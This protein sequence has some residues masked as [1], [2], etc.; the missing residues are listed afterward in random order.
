MKIAAIRT[1]AL[2]APVDPP[3]ASASGVQSRRGGLLVEVETDSG[4]VGI[5]EAGLGGGA[6]ATVI[7]KDLAPMLVG[8][9]PLM[10]EG[11]WQKMF[12]RT[13]QYGRRGVVMQGISGID[14]A[15]WDIAGKVAKLPVYKLLGACRDR[16]EAYASGGFYQEGKTAA[17][18]AGEAEGY[19][20]RGFKGM[21][22]K[23]GRN[24]STQTHLRELI[25][26]KGFCE[27]DPSEDLARVAAVRQALGPHAKLMVDVNCAWSPAFA[28]E[29]GR[30]M[31]RYNLYW[32]EEPVATDD[33]EGSARVADALATPIAG[34]E[35]EM[36]LYA[37]RE[38]I[39]RGAVDIVQLDI[40]WS[41][42]FSEGR[43]IAAYAGAHHRMVAPHAFA[44]AVL[45]VASL[46]FAAAIPNGL[47]L[48]WDQ[49][50]NAI[51]D[52]LLKE[53][54]RLESD[55]TVKLPE[56]PGLGIEL[57]RSAVE[58]YRVG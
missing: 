34:Y 33:I 49:N 35:T 20:A 25:G 43:R 6:T 45:L 58:R 15:L 36:G 41:G 27:V 26:N 28:I 4:I 16:V 23:V 31:E 7:D 13:R 50:P 32:I 12:A 9:D 53:P 39:S 51:R 14:I 19:R 54:L 21:K 5:G 48:E 24:P 47:V 57:D 46:H 11:L 8:E 29:M 22:M 18:L 3:Y 42:G 37:F 30:A 55:G 10:I 40:A 44:G 17:D 52:E 56:R 1:I 2:S 38:L